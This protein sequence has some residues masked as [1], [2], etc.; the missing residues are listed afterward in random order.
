MSD[1]EIKKL[2]YDEVIELRN[3]YHQK[4]MKRELERIAEEVAKKIREFMYSTDRWDP[5]IKVG[6]NPLPL[7]MVEEYLSTQFTIQLNLHYQ[8]HTLHPNKLIVFIREG[9]NQ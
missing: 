8:L 3:E 1:A 2:T 9:D 4:A 7:T 6:Q 5:Y